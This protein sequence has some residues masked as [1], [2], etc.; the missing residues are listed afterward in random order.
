[1][2]DRHLKPKAFK[3]HG[4]STRT[5]SFSKNWQKETEKRKPKQKNIDKWEQKTRSDYNRF[6]K[7]L[8]TQIKQNNLNDTALKELLKLQIKLEEA[9]WL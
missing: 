6:T 9:G 1:M 8:D 3:L 2:F 7:E 5:C 4:F